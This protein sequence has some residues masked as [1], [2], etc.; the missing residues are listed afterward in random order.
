MYCIEAPQRIV[1]KSMY[2]TAVPFFILNGLVLVQHA[3]PQDMI[4]PNAN[5]YVD[6]IVQISLQKPSTCKML[7]MLIPNTCLSFGRPMMS[8]AFPSSQMLV[9]NTFTSTGKSRSTC[10]MAS[11]KLLDLYKKLQLTKFLLVSVK[12]YP[13]KL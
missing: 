1:T 11:H 3:C 13:S 10:K 5:P 8:R 12:A 9:P 4:A 6:L 2:R 7:I